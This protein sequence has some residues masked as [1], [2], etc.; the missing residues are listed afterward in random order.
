[1]SLIY[2]KREVFLSSFP[3]YL[4]IVSSLLLLDRA[5]SSLKEDEQ[6]SSPSLGPPQAGQRVDHR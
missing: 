3:G 6:F 5:S 1:M 2:S 4:A